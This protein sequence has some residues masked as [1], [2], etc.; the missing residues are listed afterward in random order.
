MEKLLFFRHNR[1]S[2]QDAL[3]EK[4]FPAY[5]LTFVLEGEMIYDVDGARVVLKAGDGIFLRPGVRRGRSAA[6]G[7]DYCSTT[8]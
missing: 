5:A 8:L 4:I 7:A 3:P 6:S 1:F 2:P